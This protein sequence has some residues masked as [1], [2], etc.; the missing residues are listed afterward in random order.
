MSDS[1]A[2]E[3]AARLARY[4]RGKE[5]LSDFESWLVPLTWD[6]STEVDARAHEL[7][8]A[9]T[10]GI[11][12]YT[13]GSLTEDELKAALAELNTGPQLT[14]AGGK[15]ERVTRFQGRLAGFS[16]AGIAH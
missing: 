7:A 12:E 8:A 16:V 15:E 10:L 1:L 13:S 14:F 9:I 6:L 3:V 11:A 2:P 5:S 4:L